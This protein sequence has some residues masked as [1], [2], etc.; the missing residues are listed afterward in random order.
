MVEQRVEVHCDEP[1]VRVIV[2]S[3]EFGQDVL[4]PL[5]AAAEAAVA[6]AAVRW[7]ALD[8][9]GVEFADSTLLNLPLC[10]CVRGVWSSSVPL[11]TA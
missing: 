10:C 6:D 3:G 5:R 8:V 11:R 1:G 2:C 9:T 4:G 7:I